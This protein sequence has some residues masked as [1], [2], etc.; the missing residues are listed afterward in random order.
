MSVVTKLSLI[1]LIFTFVVAGL[2]GLVFGSTHMFSAFVGGLI[3]SVAN[4]FFAGK[5]FMNKQ[6]ELPEEMLTKFY[7]SEILKL[8]FVFAMFVIVLVFLKIEFISFILTYFFISML[9]LFCLPFL[10]EKG[11]KSN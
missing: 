4:L 2:V 7:R 9:N 1:R 5:L 6:V 3:C 11:E 8:L 10:V